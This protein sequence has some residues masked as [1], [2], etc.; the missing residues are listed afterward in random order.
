MSSNLVRGFAAAAA[1]AALGACGGDADQAKLES[2]AGA[3]TQ[4]RDSTVQA[5]D[6]SKTLHQVDTTRLGAAKTESIL[7]KARKTP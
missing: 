5:I 6:S 1:I 7:T 2:A 4:Q 3:L